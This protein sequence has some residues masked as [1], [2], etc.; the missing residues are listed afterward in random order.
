MRT[1]SSMLPET[2]MTME[3]RKML[4]RTMRNFTGKASLAPIISAVED[5]KRLNKMYVYAYMYM[6]VYTY[7]P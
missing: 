3:M 7:V 4:S 5:N 1:N 6:Y 2:S